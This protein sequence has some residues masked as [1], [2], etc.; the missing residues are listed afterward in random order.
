M[1]ERGRFQAKLAAPLAQPGE[2][3]PMGQLADPP[4]SSTLHSPQCG[5]PHTVTV[6][7]K[8]VAATT[9]TCTGTK[10]LVLCQVPSDLT[11]RH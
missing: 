3:R 4:A 5:Q 2:C 7:A 8:E 6:G 1:K 10:P 9:S 11:A